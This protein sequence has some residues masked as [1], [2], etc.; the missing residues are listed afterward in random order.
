MKKKDLGKFV[1]VIV[2]LIAI[3]LGIK[4]FISIKDWFTSLL[5]GSEEN[6]EEV[7]G[8]N[9]LSTTTPSPAPALEDSTPEKEVTQEEET[10]EKLFFETVEEA[11]ALSLQER[12]DASEISK[13]HIYDVVLTDDKIVKDESGN[14]ITARYGLNLDKIESVN[15]LRDG[16]AFLTYDQD[17]EKFKKEESTSHVFNGAI[18]SKFTSAVFCKEDSAIKSRI[19]IGYVNAKLWGTRKG[20]YGCKGEFDMNFLEK[21]IF[22]A[23]VLVKRV[24]VVDG[25]A[26]D[27]YTWCVRVCDTAV[28]EEKSGSDNGG[29]K[30]DEKPAPSEQPTEQPTEKP[31]EDTEPQPTPTPK[32]SENPTQKPAEDTET[33]PTP[34]PKENTEVEPTPTAASDS[35]ED[36]GDKPT[37][38]GSVTPVETLGPDDE[39]QF[40]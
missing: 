7:V 8:N 29:G 14:E 38:P 9:D 3:V 22:D 16:Y 12:I 31:T 34:T 26:K 19:C 37:K 39:D 21:S 40:K 4:N 20:E 33:Q 30:Q 13:Y 11:T 23:F 2:L 24:T 25:I 32:P 6:V 17:E 36:T 1:V 35:G 15:F 27:M 18:D 28:T 10:T 5:Y